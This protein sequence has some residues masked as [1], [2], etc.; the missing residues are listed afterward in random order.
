LDLTLLAKE[1]V[2]VRPGDPMAWVW[3]AQVLELTSRG[4][5][6]EDRSESLANASQALDRA[7]AIA[8]SDL[9]VLNAEYIFYSRMS[10]AV[11]IQATI[12]RLRGTTNVDPVQK[13]IALGRMQLGQGNLNEA[14]ASY[15][16]AEELG[17]KRS[18]IAILKAEALR[19]QQKIDPAIDGLETA[20]Q[21]E[22]ENG[23]LRRYYATI[24][25][26]RGTV[27]DWERIEQ[28]LTASTFSNSV[29]DNRL[30]ATLYIQRGLPSDLIKARRILDKLVLGKSDKSDEDNFRLGLLCQRSAQLQFELKRTIDGN[31]LLEDAERYLQQSLAMAP[32]R[33]DVL[34]AYGRVLLKRNRVP[35]ALAQAEQ[36]L[37]LDPDSFAANLL[38][39]S[40]QKANGNGN[41]ASGIIRSWQQRMREKV[42]PTNARTID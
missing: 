21:S 17:A 9:R 15:Q 41:A 12:E 2:E 6:R 26:S 20:L 18:A 5:S 35:D 25:G 16:A 36:L 3:Y 29:D 42:N 4:A 14:L 8:P 7:A 37:R 34:Y 39:A 28:L 11:K 10:D 40:V 32:E 33:E 27:A 38:M 19:S 23:Q 1:G 30:L 24:L 31:R 22:P 13:N